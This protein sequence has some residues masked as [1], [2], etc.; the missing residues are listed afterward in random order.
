M[1]NVNV[2]QLNRIVVEVSLFVLSAQVSSIHYEITAI[3]R[4]SEHK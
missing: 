3:N 2:S 1:A 4:V